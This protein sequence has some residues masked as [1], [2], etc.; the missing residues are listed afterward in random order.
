MILACVSVVVVLRI[1]QQ[2]LTKSPMNLP[3]LCLDSGE[4]SRRAVVATLWVFRLRGLA[5]RPSQVWYCGEVPWYC[6]EVPHAARRPHA[7]Q[8]STEPGRH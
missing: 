6:G 5:P 7:A 8:A 3:N 1:P 2:K 4:T